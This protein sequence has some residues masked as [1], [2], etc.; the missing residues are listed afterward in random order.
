MEIPQVDDPVA[1]LREHFR[2]HMRKM[3]WSGDTSGAEIIRLIHMVA[4]QYDAAIQDTSRLSGPRW[5]LLLRLV[6]EERQGNMEGITPTCLSRYQNV[7]KNTVSALLRGLEKAQLIRRELDPQDRRLFRIQLTDAGRK[8]VL[9]STPQR[10]EYLSRLASGLSQEEREKLIELLGKLY[11]SVQKNSLQDIPASSAQPGDE[12]G[13]LEERTKHTDLLPHQSA[14]AR[15]KEYAARR[16][17]REAA[18]MAR[19]RR[20]R[21]KENAEKI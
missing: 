18:R 2:E 15:K 19:S 14:L 8:L 16:A 3:E 10:L 12:A 7:S 6:I 5:G 17:E 9:S 20:S 4:N 11:R 1:F 21:I 13:E